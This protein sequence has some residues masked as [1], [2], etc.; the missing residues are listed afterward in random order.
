VEQLT[1]S[2]NLT[3]IYAVLL[4]QI[5]PDFSGSDTIFYR[6]PNDTRVYINDPKYVIDPST[7]ANVTFSSTW[8]D[9]IDNLASPA[10]TNVTVNQGSMLA[11]VWEPYTSPI[12][13][14]PLVP[15]VTSAQ[16]SPFGEIAHFIN[17]GGGSRIGLYATQQI[18][19]TKHHK[20][21]YTEVAASRF[22]EFFAT[23]TTNTFN[24]ASPTFTL[25]SK[26][27]AANMVTVVLPAVL[28][29]SGEI[30][31]PAVTVPRTQANQPDPLY[32]INP[33]A[34]TITLGKSA[35]VLR[36]T[37]GQHV[38]QKVSL[39]GT[40]LE[41]TW[42]PTDTV[43][44]PT[45][46][47]N[48]LSSATP[49]PLK[50]VKVAPAWAFTSTGS[51]GAKSGYVL[52]R[53][54]NF[55][56]VYMDRPWYETGAEELVGVIVA[57]SSSSGS[58]KLTPGL[59]PNVDPYLVSLIGFDPIAAPNPNLSGAIYPQTQLKFNN[60]ETVPSSGKLT[61]GNPCKVPM[62][63]D[64]NASIYELY[65]F[66]PQYDYDA[67]TQTG[68]QL[69][70]VDIQLDTSAFPS[71][72]PPGY[73]LQLALVRF[74]PY[75]TGNQPWVDAQGNS[76][77]NPPNWTSPV[78]L[79]TLAQPVPDRF[80][81]ASTAPNNTLSVS[82]QGEAYFGWRPQSG[83]MLAPGVLS[84]QQNPDAVPTTSTMVVEVQ[85]YST[86][87]GMTGDF[88]WSTV[89]GYTV[90]LTPVFPTGTQPYVTWQSKV[91]SQSGGIK[92][93]STSNPL[94]LQ[95]SE[96]DFF[97]PPGQTLPSKIDTTHRRPFVVHVPVSGTP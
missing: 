19:D 86:A 50:V 47:T 73:F 55:L 35:Y 93:P 59:P 63:Q 39:Y 52:S 46:T 62:P 21:T 6:S 95:I 89:E 56:R 48:I 92:L 90:A 58:D 80:V 88:A 79:L 4:P 68:S 1:P 94:R 17:P 91:T 87:S 8:T 25:N 18:G 41:I 57:Q 29:H 54:G 11:T 9:P 37:V 75:S 40:P 30:I 13:V 76:G 60:A 3:V 83:P 22:G 64:L 96:L 31:A 32:S 85:E 97:G 81:F 61:G 44:G 34:G 78:T 42:V 20:A 67:T 33:A 82:V 84:G 12:P 5:K 70:Y 72:I 14:N 49:P 24:A 36:T 16:P 15:V 26:G 2:A 69:W 53:H 74:Q 71:S 28:N 23:V 10:P 51:V 77:T 38:P 65:S 45:Y 66:A 27:I 43:T 7:T